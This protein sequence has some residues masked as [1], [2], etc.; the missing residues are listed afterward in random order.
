[1]PKTITF[2]HTSP[3]HINTFNTLIQSLA[4]D[5]PTRH[6]VA[7]SLLHEARDA[8]EITPALAARIQRT[9]IDVANDEGQVILCTCSTIGEYAEQT[10]SLINST[11]IRV[12]RP[13]AERAVELGSRIII[14]ATLASTLTPTK[15]LILSVAQEAGKTVEI[16]EWLCEAAW[17]KFEAGDQVGYI[18][19]IARSLPAV[20]TKGEVIVLAQASMAQAALLC[21]D[22][23][24]PVL[25][26]PRL[27]LAAALRAYRVA[28]SW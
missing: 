11:V 16:I 7:E 12:D 17:V 3:S 24:I 26:S 8:G 14:V 2:L 27:G 21:P 28:Q 5:V 22:L 13:M 20:A 25:S 4:P 10:N 9:I 15:Q 18:E 6:I 1:M 23:A 19:E